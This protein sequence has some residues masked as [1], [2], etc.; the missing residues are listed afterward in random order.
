MILLSGGEVWVYVWMY[1]CRSVYDVDVCMY[2][3]W[4]MDAGS[5]YMV[6][7]FMYAMGEARAREPE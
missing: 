2:D 1:V 3:V 7:D 6:R 4:C 5:G